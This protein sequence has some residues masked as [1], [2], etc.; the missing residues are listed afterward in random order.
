M[1]LD[2]LKNIVTY[3]QTGTFP[4]DKDV[5]ELCSIASVYFVVFSIHSQEIK[6]SVLFHLMDIEN[7]YGVALPSV[8]PTWTSLVMQNALK[9][10]SLLVGDFKGVAAEKISE[11]LEMYIA[12]TD[13]LQ[14]TCTWCKQIFSSDINRYRCENSHVSRKNL[15]ERSILPVGRLAHYWDSLDEPN[16]KVIASTA[17]KYLNGIPN[18]F[19]F[20]K[21]ICRLIKMAAGRV[22]I[23]GND[24]MVSLDEASELTFLYRPARPTK[25]L[26]IRHRAD[27]LAAMADEIIKK[28]AQ[29]YSDS[30]TE[31]LLSEEPQKKVVPVQPSAP[32]KKKKRVRAKKELPKIVNE[33]ETCE[34]E[35]VSISMPSIPLIQDTL[36]ELQIQKQIELEESY[37]RDAYISRLEKI[38]FASPAIASVGSWADAYD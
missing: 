30:V 15:E 38:I 10:K 33:S 22:D 35:D 2:R 16:R 12:Y 26:T 32:K 14:H 8:H 20:S 25:P 34:T 21:A 28:L 24:L 37:S 4:K 18:G 17:T 3:L 5:Q 23:T 19:N 13:I 36:L 31:A 7:N 9:F 29:M 1:E 27:A 6:R 11:T